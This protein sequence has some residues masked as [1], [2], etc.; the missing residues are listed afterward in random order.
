MYGHQQTITP[1]KSSKKK[2][3]KNILGSGLLDTS[4]IPKEKF[5]GEAI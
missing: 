1:E 2:K 4:S 5:D 3:Q